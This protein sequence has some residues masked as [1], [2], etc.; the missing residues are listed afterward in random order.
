MDSDDD[1]LQ[2]ALQLSLLSAESSSIKRPADIVDLTGDDSVW[3]G[4]E[5]QNDMDFWKAIVVSMGEG[6]SVCIVC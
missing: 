5:D 4:F 2:R 1:E 3:P 6:T